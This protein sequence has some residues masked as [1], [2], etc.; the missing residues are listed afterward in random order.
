[1]NTNNTYD[2][3]VI[4]GGLA[5]LSLAIQ[6]A[7]SGYNTILF[8][9][10]KYPF[11]R[12]CGEYISLE[13]WNFL[14]EL[15]VPLSDLHLPII[16]R[17][18]VSAPNGKYIE[19]PLPLGGFGISRYL[20]DHLLANIARREG[21]TVC[22]DTRV[23]DTSFSKDQFRI[24]TSAGEF[25]S[26]TAAGAFGKRSNLDIKW[27]RSFVQ[28]RPNKLNHYIA[29][30]Y[31]IRFPFPADLIALH[32]FENG[33][34][35][36]SNVEQDTCCLCYL[37]TADNLKSC[38]GEIREMEA[39]ILMKNPF[40][41][42]I[43]RKAKFLF[44]EPVTISQVSFNSKSQVENHVLMVGDAS[45][46]ITPLCGNGMSMAL[47]AS[48]LAFHEIRDFLDNRS[49]RFE[50]ETQYT[51]QWERLF[52]RR[53]QAGRFLQRFFGGSWQS[54]LFIQAI[55]PFPGFASFLI[56]QTHGEPF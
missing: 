19:H 32:N 8:E 9:K 4:G 39:N 53:L 33:Y 22:E 36:I 16:Q 41:E 20:I 54:N 43:F 23:I 7:R 38:N 27:R 29:V 46:M 24:Q 18:M 17:V 12:V 15:G 47:H 1:L 55:K 49:S 26:R 30:K 51:Q 21:V 52:G 56:K 42:E 25:V 48:K 3:A 2:L 14:Q 34:C 11:H 45:G 13:S 28:R 37:T 35:G 50:M 10:E 31:H 6:S 5:G 44:E 40:L